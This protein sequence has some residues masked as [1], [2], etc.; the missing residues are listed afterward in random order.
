MVQVTTAV[1]SRE[2]AEE[3]A[4]S[5]VEKRLAACAQVSGPVTSFFAWKGENC[6]EEEWL[7]VMKTPSSR[8]LELME[9]VRRNHPYETP[10]IIVSPV[11]GALQEYLDWMTEV[12]SD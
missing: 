5:S 9:F 10:E 3:I 8:S 6:K 11:I 7:C 12:T 2:I 4:R 1:G